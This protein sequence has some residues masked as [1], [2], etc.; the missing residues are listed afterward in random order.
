MHE[1]ED[2]F[3]LVTRDRKLNQRLRLLSQG[4]LTKILEILIIVKESAFE[5]PRHECF[6]FLS[7]LQPPSWH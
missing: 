1:N 3:V 5:M 2:S 4:R 7:H 6:F